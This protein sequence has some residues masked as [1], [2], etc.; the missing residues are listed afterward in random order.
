MRLLKRSIYLMIAIAMMCGL[1][2]ISSET[3]FAAD[4]QVSVSS[5]KLSSNG[6]KVVV[7]AK[8]K[9]KTKQM[10]NKLYLFA[11][12]A[13]LSE[14]GTITETPIAQVQA[15]KGTVTF[16]VKYKS[17]MLFRKFVV[18]Y[19]SGKKYRIISDARYITNP[20]KLATY[21]GTGVKTTSKKGMQAD[22]GNDG[23]DASAE[24]RT[25][26]VVLNWSID[27]IL[28]QNCSNKEVYKYKNKKYTF[29]KDKVVWLQE[30]VRLHIENGSKVYVI[31]LLKQ[32]AGGQA[33]K[34][35]Y[36]GGK[37]YSSINT[38]SYTACQTWE[39]FMTYMAQQ[40]GTE[41]TLVS[42]WIL[43]NEVDSPYDWNYAGGKD[44]GSYMEDY[45][46]AYRIAYNAAKSVSSNSK[47]YISLDYNWNYDTDGGG[48]AYF[49]SKNTL[50]TFYSKLKSQGKININ[51]AYHAYPQGLISPSFWDDF[52]ATNDPSTKLVN[53]NNITILTDYVKKNFGKDATIMLSEQAFNSTEG[54]ALQA[55]AFAY[56][57]YISE[58]N[59]MIE[60]FIYPRDKDH[61]SDVAQGFYWGLRDSAGNKRQIWDILK[62]IDSKE[63]L[64]KTSHLVGYTNLSS[65]TQIPGIDKNTF[66]NN[67]S[68]KKKWPLVAASSL[69]VSLDDDYFLVDTQFVYDGKKHKPKV[70][71]Q[72]NYTG[73]IVASKH[74]TVKYLTDCKSVG[75]HKIQIKLKGDYQGTIIRTFKIVPKNA[76]LSIKKVNKNS[77]VLN[78][79]M[80]AKDLAQIDGYIIEY[81]KGTFYSQDA[82]IQSVKVKN[83]KTM[84]TTIKKL[85]AG[86]TY[87]FRILPYKT[88]IVD[89]KKMDLTPAWDGEHVFTDTLKK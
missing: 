14:S 66:K 15:K 43:G 89:G 1:C 82:K 44:L 62:C 38:S 56:A 17:T 24:L 47:V 61:P 75:V 53:M 3:I 73:E 13:H 35:S 5:C 63:S 40:F 42:G 36:G 57:Y 83:S 60:S 78:W 65:W 87:D 6:S 54:E 21:T 2:L 45:A 51:I 72:K 18:A 12:N 25:Q 84:K 11:L 64:D 58:G 39:A 10:G 50:D 9:Q 70:T 26:H 46:R 59:D 4:K 8:V 49:T 29:D 79:E 71:V 23:I 28:T 76:V 32:D 80:S 85:E 68:I 74:Y 86:T 69:Y 33:G 22:L 88:V 31:L 41:L 67:R 20:E 81:T 52:E 34:M 19:K 30:Q 77:V 16:S 48:T 7:K 37:T 55:A 27:E